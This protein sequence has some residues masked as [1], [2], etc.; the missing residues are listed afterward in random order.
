M[1]IAHVREA[2]KQVQTLKE[3]LLEAKQLAECYGAKLE[4]TH[5]AGLAGLLHDLGKYS[6]EFQD[7][8]QKAAFFPEAAVKKRGQVDHSTAGGKLLFNMLHNRNNTIYEKLLA[9]IVGNAIISH[10]A[11]LQD[12]ISP[13]IESDY[14]KRVQDK[15]LPEYDLAVNRFFQDTVT[16]A[17]FTEYIAAALEELKRFIN[18]IPTQSFFLTKFVFSCLLDADR[19][20]TRQ[21]EEP[22]SA[23]AAPQYKPSFDSYYQKLMNHLAS[24][25]AKNNADDP[26]NQL[27]SAMSEQCEIFAEK[28][29]GIYTLSIPT[30]GGKTLASL[31][32]AL[33]HG[34]I[35]GK[36]RMIYVVPFTTIIEQNA[37][38]VRAILDDD[39][40][41][42]EHHS[43]V[44]VE[45][46]TGDEHEDGLITKK[47]KLKL[48]R[49]NW[50]S[51]I[52]FTTLVQFL[53]VFY[54]KGNR[55]TRRLHNISHSVVIFDEVQKVPTKCVSLFNEALNFLKEK[56]H[57][58]ILLC[59]ATQPALEDV[60]YRLLKDRDGEIVPN[61]ADVSKAF[62]RVEIN[63][64]T[65]KPVTNE[66]LAEWIR[67][68]IQALGSTL[69]ILNTKAVVKD[70]YEKL[71][72][73]SLPVSHLSTSMCAAHRKV[74]LEEMRKLLRKGTPF[75]CVTTQL[76]EAGVD[77]SFKCVIRSLAGLDSI[78]QAAGRCN[79]HGEDSLRDVYVIDHA[80]ERLS[81]LPEIEVGKGIA[82]NVLARY[83][84][85]AEKYEASLL[86]Q[87]AMREYFLFFYRKMESNLN[88]YVPEADKEMTK[89]L[90]AHA[91]E[92]DYVTHYR[93]K[94]GTSFPLV[95]NGSYKTAADHFH[96]IDQI[97]TSVIVP[98]GEGKELAAEL[99][100]REWVEDLTK[101]L[102]K[103]Q[104]YTVNLYSQEFNQ[105]QKQGALVAHL[106]GMIYEL[107]ENWYSEE[108]GID[109]KGEGGMAFTSF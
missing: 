105:L 74:Q 102:K 15:N 65:D 37:Q 13:S 22:A 72:D 84:K 35:F 12:Y 70:L 80:E 55:N 85:K 86:S 58:S 59:T 47:E 9:E 73:M 1:Y 108:Y 79:R 39:E 96:V 49:D 68:D 16:K 57:C 88:Y 95:L 97:T 69:V 14:L 19:T 82:G 52:I 41:I 11:N 91:V 43:N 66:Q 63:D 21:F 20:N 31:R 92:N 17:E 103:A 83:K 71:Q 100:S 28:P 48:A 104:Q 36:Q 50:D 107:K 38:E 61:L 56:A 44:V 81:N 45:E 24:L 87:T 60:K 8:I 34:Q 2:D 76:I 99:N 23:T 51:P 30:G 46:E 5:V 94:K 77:V 40:H 25:K 54:A 18:D 53:N 26:I 4:L 101:L 3:H 33:K 62:K 29:S 75:L 93:K 67:A 7:Y 6:D 98:Y 10:H 42:L 32:Y 90:L 106:D 64:K 78:A 27:R 89:L 109:L